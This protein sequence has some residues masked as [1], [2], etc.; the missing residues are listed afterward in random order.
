MSEM[1]WGE[2]IGER[3]A[4]ALRGLGWAD[5]NEMSDLKNDINFVKATLMV[6]Y[7]PDGHQRPGVITGEENIRSMLI[8]VLQHLEEW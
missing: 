4:R 6:N 7:G 5:P 1:K 8:T 3:T 2:S